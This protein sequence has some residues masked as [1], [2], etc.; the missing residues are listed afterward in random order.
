[1]PTRNEIVYTIANALSGGRS[2]NNTKHSLRQI[3]FTVDYY[4]ALLLRR[5]L[6]KYGRQVDFEQDLG[7][8]PLQSGPSE[9]I[10][11]TAAVPVPV[12]LR[13]TLPLKVYNPNTLDTIPVVDY[14]AG[15]WLKYRAYT[16]GKAYAWYRSG[17]IYI[18]NPPAIM[19]EVPDAPVDTVNVR[20]IFESPSDVHRFLN[21]SSPTYTGNEPYPV[22]SDLVEQIVKG[23]LSG[24]MRIQ[25]GNDKPEPSDLMQ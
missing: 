17:K 6:D 3:A 19:A 2:E 9:T 15:Q 21:P 25:A 13:Y 20:G 4:R 7:E 24:E 14:A 16:A 10:F 23:I 12:R 1:M 11:T 5:D 18:S 8:I 22:T